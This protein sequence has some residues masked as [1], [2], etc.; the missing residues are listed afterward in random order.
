MY[1]DCY[2]I[3]FLCHFRVRTSPRVMSI[4]NLF[5]AWSLHFFVGRY[6]VCR[7]CQVCVAI[8]LIVSLDC[9]LEIVA[10]IQNDTERE[11]SG[12]GSTNCN[13]FLPL[14]LPPF[15]HPFCL[16]DARFDSTCLCKYCYFR[17]ITT[18]WIVILSS[19]Y[20]LVAS[21]IR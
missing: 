11:Q 8:C 12:I 18:F 20:A 4:T 7:L 16:F 5:I 9:G 3:A 2:Y 14:N 19:G 13:R 15:S 17:T 6:Y 21:F 10:V 1:L